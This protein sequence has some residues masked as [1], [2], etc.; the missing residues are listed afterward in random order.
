MFKKISQFWNKIK[1]VVISLLV[2]LFFILLAGLKKILGPSKFSKLESKYLELE[3]IVKSN[4]QKVEAWYDS[5]VDKES[6]Y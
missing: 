2:K 1:Q 5:K 3:Q 4:W 6:K